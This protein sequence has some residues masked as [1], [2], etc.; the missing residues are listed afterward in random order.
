MTRHVVK[1][2]VTQGAFG[3]RIG[4]WGVPYYNYTVMN[5]PNPILIVKALLL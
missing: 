5:L 2:R 3:I 1:F 4:L